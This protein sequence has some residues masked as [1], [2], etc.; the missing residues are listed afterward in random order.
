MA[1]GRAQEFSLIKPE[2]AELRGIS[3]ALQLVK[4]LQGQP[5]LFDSDCLEAVKRVN[6]I[7]SE[8]KK[9][10]NILVQVISDAFKDLDFPL[11]YI[12]RS[13]NVIAHGIADGVILGDTF[14]RWDLSLQ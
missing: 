2:E 12:P 4:C 9:D 1:W 5:I 6:N 11:S 14:L 7:S 10:F 13:S 3:R 8:R